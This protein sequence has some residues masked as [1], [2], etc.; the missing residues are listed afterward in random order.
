MIDHGCGSGI[1]AIAI[2]KYGA[3]QVTAIDHNPQALTAT[4]MNAE[5]NNIP[6]ERLK[7]VLLKDVQLQESVDILLANILAQ[8]LIDLATY[9]RSL[10]KTDS[11]CVL[12][13][14]LNEQTDSVRQAYNAAGFKIIDIHQQREWVCLVGSAM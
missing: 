7:I 11:Y 6:P 4:L 3:K 12:A 8:P 10:V 9:F 13:G 1:L 14:I 5:Q 2:L